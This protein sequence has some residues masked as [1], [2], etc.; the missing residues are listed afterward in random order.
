M[1]LNEENGPLIKDQREENAEIK[2]E[3]KGL[4]RGDLS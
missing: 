1:F 2:E 4:L 3:M